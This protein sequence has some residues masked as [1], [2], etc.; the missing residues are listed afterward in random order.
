MHKAWCQII[1]VLSVSQIPCM[2]LSK[3]SCSAQNFKYE[4]KQKEGRSFFSTLLHR[5]PTTKCFFAFTLYLSIAKCGPKYFHFLLFSPVFS[6]LRKISKCRVVANYQNLGGGITEDY[7]I[8]GGQTENSLL[9]K[10]GSM[11]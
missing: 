5:N 1:V 10:I 11:Q 6:P 4:T 8:N 9:A 3:K 2:F 7:G